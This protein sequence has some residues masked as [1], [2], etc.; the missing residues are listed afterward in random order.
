[1][2]I[3]KSIFSFVMAVTMVIAVSSCKKNKP[4]EEAKPTKEETPIPPPPPA[5]ATETLLFGDWICDSNKVWTPTPHLESTYVGY[6]LNLT[7]N[8][9]PSNSNFVTYFAGGLYGPLQTP[10]TNSIW[11]AVDGSPTYSHQVLIFLFPT[12][13]IMQ[14]TAN[15]LVLAQTDQPGNAR[16]IY[17]HK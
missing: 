4:A 12:T 14:V 1:M 5:T 7:S 16:T 3:S 13:V 11:K 8:A 10:N 15:S 6:H 9:Y 17:F 2:K